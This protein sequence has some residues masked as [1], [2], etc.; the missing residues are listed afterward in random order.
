MHCVSLLGIVPTQG[1]ETILVE[2]LQ[3]KRTSAEHHLRRCF[4]RNKDTYNRPRCTI[5]ILTF[6]ILSNASFV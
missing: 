3:P 2:I 5:K 1:C 6:T 4:F